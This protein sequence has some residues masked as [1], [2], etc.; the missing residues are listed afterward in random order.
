MPEC[1]ELEG[2]RTPRLSLLDRKKEQRRHGTK[3]WE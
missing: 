2:A 1:E 3:E